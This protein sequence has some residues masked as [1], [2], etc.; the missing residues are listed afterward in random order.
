[1]IKKALF[2]I[3][4]FYFLPPLIAQDTELVLKM[5]FPNP[6]S[7]I[8]DDYLVYPYDL[9][10]FDG[11]Y[12]VCDVKDSCLKVFSKSG[13]FIRKIGK[14]GQG[15]GEM[16]TVFHMTLD[17]QN[18]ILFCNDQGNGRISSFDIN[19]EFKGMIRTLKPPQNIEYTSGMIHASVYDPVRRSL[20]S[21]YDSAGTLVKTYGEIFD[22]N[23]PENRFT[24]N[25]Y[26]RVNLDSDENHFY[27][28]YSFIPYID[29]YSHQG[30]FIR[31][32]SIDVEEINEI[33]KKNIDGVKQG[34]VNNRTLK[35]LPWNMGACV[36]DNHFYYLTN[37]DF[38]EILILNPDGK[39][40]KKIPFKT[41]ESNPFLRLITLSDKDYI[42]IAIDTA[43]V[44]IYEE[45]Q[46]DLPSANIQPGIR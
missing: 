19:G 40:Q 12:I 17:S 46:R 2:L 23:I 26:S 15:P 44:K 22:D 36:N 10:I 6:D 16:N 5:A 18:G 9:E 43:Q 45:V 29:I 34:L 31:R 33:Y 30:E 13:E 20:Y 7:M 37:F 8:E 32:L 1:M 21:M 25:L 4:C 27:A 14:R 3:F 38:N 42:F 11:F 28:L 41:R 24:N 35:I 39:F